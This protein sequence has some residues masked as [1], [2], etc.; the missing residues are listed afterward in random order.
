MCKKEGSDPKTLRGFALPSSLAGLCLSYSR[1]DREK[2]SAG[3][4]SPGRSI[5]SWLL[6]RLEVFQ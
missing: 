2:Q 5:T 4:S 1:K 6:P 3:L